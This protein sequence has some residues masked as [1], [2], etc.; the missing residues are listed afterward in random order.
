MDS[1][2][3]WHYDTLT[4]LNTYTL[5]HLH[6]HT[7][8]HLHADL[9]IHYSTHK[10][11]TQFHTHTLAHFH[12]DARTRRLSC[13]RPDERGRSAQLRAHVHVSDYRRRGGYSRHRRAHGPVSSLLP[14][15]A[16]RDI[17]IRYRH[18]DTTTQTTTT[19]TVSLHLETALYI[20]P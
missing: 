3:H 5:K 2:T 17:I 10:H 12:T 8:T 15:A 1:L 16:Q 20:V 13:A 7:R 6:T 18:Y 14:S 9:L 19:T 11:T 4:R